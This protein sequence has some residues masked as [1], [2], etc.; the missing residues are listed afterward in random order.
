MWSGVK[1]IV[2]CDI[3][4]WSGETVRCGK[5]WRDVMWS[6]TAQSRTR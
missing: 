1:V 3:E 5:V 2:R 4:M 6:D